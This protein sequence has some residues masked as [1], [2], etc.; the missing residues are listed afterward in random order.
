ME[1]EKDAAV[2]EWLKG[3]GFI[4]ATRALRTGGDY[5]GI[6]YV[7]HIGVPYGLIDFAQETGR[8]GRAREE[9][10]LI[11]LLEDSEYRQLKRQEAAEL[12]VD[13]L[14]MQ[15]FIQTREC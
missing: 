9:V 8:G 4:A 14:A 11:I 6:V 15:R 3:E 5:P 12:T 2:E 7:V 1:D 13:E 10:D